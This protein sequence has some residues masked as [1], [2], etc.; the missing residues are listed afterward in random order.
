LIVANIP[1]WVGSEQRRNYTIFDEGR[2]LKIDSVRDGG[3]RGE[4]WWGKVD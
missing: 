3:F 2:V 4:L 1:D